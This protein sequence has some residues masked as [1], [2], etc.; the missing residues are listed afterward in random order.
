MNDGSVLLDNIE[1]FNDVIYNGC[2]YSAFL[3]AIKYYNKNIFH[4]LINDVIIYDF[5]DDQQLT[6]KY[7][8]I[9]SLENLMTDALIGFNLKLK[10]ENIVND[11]KKSI[12]QGKPVI[13]NVDYYYESIRKDT[14]Q[15]IH[16][17]HSLLIYG[18]DDTSEVLY[19]LEHKNSESIYYEKCE[20]SYYDMINCY[21]G[22]LEKFINLDIVKSRYNYRLYDNSTVY[23]TYFEIYEEISKPEILNCDLKKIYKQNMYNKLD[24]IYNGME[25]L[26]EFVKY[27]ENIISSKELLNLES[28]N[29]LNIMNTIINAKRIEEY[30]VKHLF[31]NNNYIKE[32]IT[33]ILNKWI[34]FRCFILKYIITQKYESKTIEYLRASIIEISD[35]EI[36]FVKKLLMT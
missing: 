31:S 29:L 17:P 12:F 26:K 22:Y 3:S 35:L 5:N 32:L 6:I 16:G 30:R 9:N 2:F 27:F 20:L 28:N 18:Y 19:I 36:N 23:P 1:P 14:F 10:S 33:S 34:E 21:K 8:S 15:K 25:N 4:F 24:E 7:E 11:L 13:V